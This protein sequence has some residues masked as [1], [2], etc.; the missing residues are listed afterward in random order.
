[1]HYERSADL[2]M[3]AML[4]CAFSEPPVV[5]RK[6]DEESR[7][8]NATRMP[9]RGHLFPQRVKPSPDYYPSEEVAM[10]LLESATSGLSI[11]FDSRRVSS[12]PHSANSSTGALASDLLATSSASGTPPYHRPIRSNFERKDSQT[13]SLST[14]PEQHRHVH[15]SNSNLSVFAASFQR[16]F[17][18]SQSAASS[19]PNTHPK[20][21]LSP[22]G[23]Y[24]GPTQS[25]INWAPST[26]GG[27][28]FFGR[29]TMGTVNPRTALPL[30]ASDTE[31]ENP[32]NTSHKV[33]FTTTLK[34]Q[35][36]FCN[37]GYSNVPLLEPNREDTYRKWRA[38]YAEMLYAWEIPIARCQILG[39]NPRLSLGPQT[40]PIGRSLS[41]S[42][43]ANAGD[44]QPKTHCRNCSALLPISPTSSRCIK[45]RH[46]PGPAS[47][48][49]CNSYIRGL[50]SPCLSCG[51]VMH[52]A[53]RAVVNES[54]MFDECI[55]GCGC[56]CS[57]HA[58]VGMPM[59]EAKQQTFSRNRDG[60]PAVTVVADAAT[61]EQEQLGWR[62]GDWD[63]VAYES[64]ARNLQGQRRGSGRGLRATTSQIWRGSQ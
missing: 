11:R 40:L 34:N 29:P 27:P 15:R 28:G 39:Y 38:T 51:H 14:S 41:A 42:I 48:L 46:L 31:D 49:L 20:K 6:P 30:A 36:K 60:N 63:D 8:A 13:V 3:L 10:S 5:S 43:D 21:R 33:T 7:W 52:A 59:P 55:S 25:G 44:I 9:Q 53:C 26:W 58:S 16:P 24:L 4:S 57:E 2:Q 47:C 62:E 61:N 22:A 23:S 37:D 17:P 54:G 35:D 32:M 50:S 1:M 64:L 12:G 56:I 45:C 18:I 19:P